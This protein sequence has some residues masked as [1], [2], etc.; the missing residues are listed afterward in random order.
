MIVSARVGDLFRRGRQSN[1]LR[2]G[3]AIA[4]RPKGGGRVTELVHEREI[5]IRDRGGVVYDRARVYAERQTDGTWSGIIEFLSAG[6]VHVVRTGRETTQSNV[7]AV[8]YWATGL[9]A[10]Y[11]E[12]A[13]GRAHRH[14]S[15]LA[16][17]GALGVSR[18]RVAF[19]EVVSADP[20]LPLRLMSTRTLAPGWRRR[21]ADGGLIV[22]EGTLQAPTASEAGRYA[23]LVQFTSE[24]GAA[25]VANALWSTLHM[26][27]AGVKIEGVHVAVNHSEMKETLIRT[28]RTLG[29]AA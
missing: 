29:R 2:V 1:R 26:D 12:G 3:I 4:A 17:A 25:L 14:P 10:S 16:L 20:Q 27:V 24:N 9:Q 15:D 22:Y 13:L 7:A 11:L 8:A 6:G 19:V 28:A 21:V 23:F 5:T 18:W